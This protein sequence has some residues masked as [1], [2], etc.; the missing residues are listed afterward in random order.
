MELTLAIAII[1]CVISVSS[2]TLSRKD[3]ANKDTHNDAYKWGVID[4]QIKEIL[5]KLDKIDL[6]L[7]TFDKEVEEKI[8]NAMENHIKIYHRGE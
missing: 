6:K 2:F 3:K 7:D 8:N 1:S 5:S 4:Q